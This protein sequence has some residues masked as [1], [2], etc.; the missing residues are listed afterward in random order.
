MHFKIQTW[1]GLRFHN[2]VIQLVCPDC[3]KEVWQP[4]KILARELGDDTPLTERGYRCVVCG[5]K[6]GVMRPY[7]AA[8]RE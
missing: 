8:F 3:K 2:G 5:C 7:I 6:Y 4:A 1:G